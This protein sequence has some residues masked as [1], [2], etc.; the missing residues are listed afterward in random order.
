[1]C[2][3]TWAMNPGTTGDRRAPSI[4][5]FPA[6]SDEHWVWYLSDVLT[7][8][9]GAGAEGPTGIHAEFSLP[10]LDGPFRQPERVFFNPF[11]PNE[12]WVTSFGGGVMV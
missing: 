3:A 10:P 7:L 1:M 4:S 2:A 5:S 6:P 8:V 12:V 9:P 11:N